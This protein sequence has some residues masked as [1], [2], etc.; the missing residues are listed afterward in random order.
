MVILMKKQRFN[1][2]SPLRRLVVGVIENVKKKEEE[3][4]NN[5]EIRKALES[6]GFSDG[7]ESVE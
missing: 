3:I 6:I 1:P 7:G 2:M 5:E 4:R